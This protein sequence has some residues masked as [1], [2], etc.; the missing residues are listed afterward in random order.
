MSM[1]EDVGEFD[2]VSLVSW[3]H[4]W[5]SGR[6]KGCVN[7]LTFAPPVSISHRMSPTQK[8]AFPPAWLGIHD[9]DD[10]FFD[11]CEEQVVEVDFTPI[12]ETRSA[13]PPVSIILLDHTSA[14]SPPPPP[15]TRRPAPPPRRH[16]DTFISIYEEELITTLTGHAHLTLPTTA[17][18]PAPD[19]TAQP[20][21]NPPA[22]ASG[23]GWSWRLVLRVVLVLLA[24]CVGWTTFVV[25]GL[26]NSWTGL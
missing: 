2:E 1:S 19:P 21:P 10:E 6:W 25:L 22:P 24:F 5:W 9:Q 13:P 14:P 8:D 16:E 23:P 12:L 4:E 15:P 3:G 17:P 20:E 18:S 7:S 11:A 26:W